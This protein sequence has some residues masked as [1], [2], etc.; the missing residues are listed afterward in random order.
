MAVTERTQGS[1]CNIC[2]GK[3]VLKGFNDFA[4]KFPELAKQAK[5]W[6][7]STVTTQSKKKYLWHC[8]AGGGHDY[9][10]SPQSRAIGHGCV[11]CSG[12]A[13]LAGFN[14]FASRYPELANQAD[15]W[16][17]EK[18]VFG[19]GRLLPWKCD[20]KHSFKQRPVDRIAG[21]GCKYCGNQALLVGFN[22]LASKYPEIAKQAL[23]WDPTQVLTG[24]HK[25]YNWQCPNNAEHQWKATVGSRV[26]GS[27]CPSCA[28]GGFDPN[29]PAWLYFLSHPDWELLQIGISNVPKDRL[30]SHRSSGWEVLE[31]RGSM[32]GDVTYRWEQ[33]ILNAIKKR[34]VK[35][36]P[37][38]IAGKFSGYTESWV[39]KDLP[40][41]SLSELM[42]LV[43][44]DEG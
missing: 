35:L 21:N 43:H 8:E 23:E 24:S 15:G 28:V 34:G 31:L 20:L 4:S 42:E 37:D 16:D 25:I 10:T 3:V 44:N 29:E 13:V 1:N 41:K 33:D 32:P 38:H 26:F 19:S 40:A 30:A 5:G 12:Q 36:G 14:D 7:P 39:K 22:D 27:G 6:D 9:V 11:Y 2:A 18:I 17:P